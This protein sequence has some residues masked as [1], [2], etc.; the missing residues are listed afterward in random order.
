[1]I[2]SYDVRLVVR[3]KCGVVLNGRVLLKIKKSQMSTRSRFFEIVKTKHA[4]A[5]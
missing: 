4:G 3:V 5:L 1:M 2:R